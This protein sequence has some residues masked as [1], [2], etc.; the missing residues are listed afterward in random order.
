MKL[1]IKQ[2]KQIIKEQVEEDEGLKDPAYQAEQEQNRQKSL[3]WKKAHEVEVEP[4]FEEMLKDLISTARDREKP[5]DD[6]RKIYYNILAKLKKL[7]V[8]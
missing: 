3:E 4:S 1:T 6:V 8:R 2:L 7:G 5:Y